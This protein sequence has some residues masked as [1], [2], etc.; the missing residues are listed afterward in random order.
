MEMSA[1]PRSRTLKRRR[2]GGLRQK[3]QL[4]GLFQI[5]EQHEFYNL[6]CM[7]KEGLA[8][9]I[10]STSEHVPTAELSEDDFKSEI[11]HIHKGFTMETFAALCSPVCAALWA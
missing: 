1:R 9:A 11:T 4:L 7:M 6:T 10:Q 8:A 2:W 3:W 5:D